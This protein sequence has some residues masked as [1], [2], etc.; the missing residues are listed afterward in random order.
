VTDHWRLWNDH[1]AACTVC[2]RPVGLCRTGKAL[3]ARTE[4]PNDG[5]PPESDVPAQAQQPVEGFRAFGATETME[6]NGRRVGVIVELTLE[7]HTGPI[8]A[9]MIP[10]ILRCLASAGRGA[11]VH[12]VPEGG[13]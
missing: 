8:T 5:T 2:S 1:A 6:V 4:G 9:D 11:G 12:M 10:A 3:L 7:G 13:A